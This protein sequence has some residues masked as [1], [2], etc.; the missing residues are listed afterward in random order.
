[1]FIVT[2]Y[3]INHV[4]KYIEFFLLMMYNIDKVDRKNFQ[5]NIFY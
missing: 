3:T 5:Y 4:E 2:N 1:M